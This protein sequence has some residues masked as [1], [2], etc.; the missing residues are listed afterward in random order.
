MSVT[1]AAD[2][3]DD[4]KM[5]PDELRAYQQQQ[6]SSSLATPLYNVQ[7]AV[8]SSDPFTL[9]FEFFSGVSWSDSPLIFGDFFPYF[10]PAIGIESLV[11]A[12]QID[13]HIDEMTHL[14]HANWHLMDIL[15]DELLKNIPLSE[16][17]RRRQIL[18]SSLARDGVEPDEGWELFDYIGVYKAFYPE[19]LYNR[20][21][22]PL[23]IDYLEDFLYIHNQQGFYN[24]LN[25]LVANSVW[26]IGLRQTYDQLIELNQLTQDLY[27]QSPYHMANHVTD[28]R[29]LPELFNRQ[30]QALRPLPR[31]DAI[32]GLLS[33]SEHAHAAA[34]LMEL[35]QPRRNYG[36]ER[37]PKKRRKF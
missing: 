10:H 12:G 17:H 35:G 1:T 20:W 3:D 7:D 23:P 6:S 13:S 19:H 9:I 11:A 5:S 26:D 33:L 18:L 22:L 15:G 21:I 31:H 8:F 36:D 28:L 37:R 27:Y 16:T 32:E 25:L 30:R 34:A 4:R 24:E 2:D 29:A 14:Y